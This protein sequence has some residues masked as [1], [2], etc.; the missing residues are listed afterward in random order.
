MSDQSSRMRSLKQVFH[1]LKGYSRLG[2]MGQKR[3]KKLRKIG[4]EAQVIDEQREITELHL[5]GGDRTRRQ[6]Q[7]QPRANAHGI[8]KGRTQELFQYLISQHRDTPLL[9]ELLEVLNDIW[10][11]RCDLD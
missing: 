7:D 3:A 4:N 11:C 9:I 1:A 5:T 6:H 8:A 2:I 10:L